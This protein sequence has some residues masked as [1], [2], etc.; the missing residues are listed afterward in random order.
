MD[1]DIVT[2]KY[3]LKKQ[4]RNNTAMIINADDFGYSESVNKAISDCFERGLINRTTIMVNMPCAEAAAATAKEKGFFDKVGLHINLTEG[5]ALSAKCSASPLCDENGYFKGTFHI[6]FKSRLY[7]PKAVRRAIFAEVEAQINKYIEMG[8]T[9]MHADSHNYTHSYLSVYSEVGKL[10]KKYNFKSTRISRN[11]SPEDFSF[12]FKLYKDIF[13][14]L[15]R[16]LKTGDGHIIRTEKYFG[17]VQ[18]FNGCKDKSTVKNSLE[19]MTHPDYIDGVLTDNT[20]P[21]PHPFVTEE[22]IREN[23]LILQ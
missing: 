13:N 12:L 9:L 19:L 5:K 20:L 17:S 7:L 16:N 11:V 21:N 8:F 22:W 15:I 14:R 2:Q 6:P 4:I 1:K 23:G 18:D 10:L 3:S